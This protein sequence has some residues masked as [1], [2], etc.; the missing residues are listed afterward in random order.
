M[1]D[2]DLPLFISSYL[3]VQEQLAEASIKEMLESKLLIEGFQMVDDLPVPGAMTPA[4]EPVTLRCN[5][6]P[7]LR[8]AALFFS[9]RAW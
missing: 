9:S 6:S 7:S 2:T 5:V 8:T 1:E 4:S 3:P